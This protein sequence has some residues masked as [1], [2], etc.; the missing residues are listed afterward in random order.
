MFDPKLAPLS[1]DRYQGNIGWKT[2]LALSILVLARCQNRVSVVTSVAAASVGAAASVAYAASV[3]A[4]IQQ[5]LP[6]LQC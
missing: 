4:A 5:L 2:A 3:A 1:R 6:L